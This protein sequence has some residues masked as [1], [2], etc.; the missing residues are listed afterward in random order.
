MKRHI[1]F[2]VSL[3]ISI[4]GLSQNKKAELEIDIW[5]KWEILAPP[6]FD[7]YFYTFIKKDNYG[8]LVAEKQNTKHS[9][10]FYVVGPDTIKLKEGKGE[11]FFR[12]ATEKEIKER[13]LLNSAPEKLRFSKAGNKL[14]VYGV[15]SE[16]TAKTALNLIRAEYPES[17]HSKKAKD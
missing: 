6:P 11:G 15:M 7:G 8:V 17:K 1:L 4:S 16:P 14:R 3:I 12:E 5:G 13:I 10:E 2:F 9:I